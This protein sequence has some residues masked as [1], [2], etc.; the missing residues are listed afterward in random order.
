MLVVGLLGGRLGGPADTAP[1]GGIGLL[2]LL[3][4]GGAPD[5]LDV[6][7]VNPV[8]AGVEAEVGIARPAGELCPIPL[9]G[10]EGGADTLGGGGV[11]DTGVA[12]LAPAFLFTHFLS[13]GSK[14][15]EFSS[16][17]LALIGPAGAFGSRLNHPPNQPFFSDCALALAAT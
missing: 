10:L 2:A 3:A 1:G 13:S 11:A 9:A 7:G 5:P 8:V 16:P 12:A 17:S 14:T 15:K 6:G 4:I